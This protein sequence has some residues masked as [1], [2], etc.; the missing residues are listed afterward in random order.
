MVQ[1][2]N[3]L[4]DTLGDATGGV[5]GTLKGLFAKKIKIGGREY[6]LVLIVGG[7]GVIGILG[8]VTLKNRGH[9]GGFSLPGGDGGFSSNGSGGGGGFGGGFQADVDQAAATEQALS[10][11]QQQLQDTLF[12]GQSDATQAINDLIAQAQS[13]I[14]TQPPPPPF[15]P[16]TLPYSE[17]AYTIES[18][19]TADFAS[20]SPQPY[21]DY[22]TPYLQPNTP[23]PAPIRD[24]LIGARARAKAEAKRKPIR[25][26]DSN[27]PVARTQPLAGERSQQKARQIRDDKGRQRPSMQP[28]RNPIT[29]SSFVS[30]MRTVYRPSIPR[31]S[32]LPIIRPTP[33]PLP[34]PPSIVPYRPFK[35]TPPKQRQPQ[36]FT[37]K[38]GR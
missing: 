19:P 38:K 9:G 22:S 6:P 16:E 12:Q 11:A 20:Y 17:P 35:P 25:P 2:I 28:I 1:V 13:Q 24:G 30:P 29:M 26:I 31:P 15:Y 4:E 34:R 3:D 23:A 10:G 7:V 33:Q 5:K 32:M 18:I 37:T 21:P 8:Y 27:R 36:R 14:Q